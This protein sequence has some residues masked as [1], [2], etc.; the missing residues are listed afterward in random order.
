[1]RSAGTHA[2]RAM[3]PLSFLIRKVQV[4]LNLNRN[5]K[6]RHRVQQQPKNGG[7]GHISS[8]G[9]GE[10]SVCTEMYKCVYCVCALNKGPSIINLINQR[11][12]RQG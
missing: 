7:I 9:A 2:F 8:E 1:M 10:G 3:V 11:R 12:G 6:A 4:T 5:H